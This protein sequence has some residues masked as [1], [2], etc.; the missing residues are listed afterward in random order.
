MIT[1]PT[2]ALMPLLFLVPAIDPP[3]RPFLETHCVRCHNA[4]ERKGNLDL[5]R[6]LDSARWMRLY[7]RVAAGEMPPTPKKPEPA[8]QSGALKAIADALIAHEKPSFEKNGRRALRRLNRTEYENTLR[9]LL[10]LPG[11][12]VKE[13]LPDDGRSHG[14]DKSADAL[15]LSPLLIAKYA[16]AADHALTQAIAPFAVPPVPH[17]ERIYAHHNYDFGVVIPNGDGVMLKDFK[18]DDSRFPIPSDAYAGGKFKGL[19]ELE[20]SRE[21][22]EPGTSGLFRRLG[23]AFAGRLSQFSPTI[24]GRYRIRLSVWS[25]WWEKGTVKP[26]PRTQAAGLYYGARTLGYFDAP[27]LKPREHMLEVHLEPGEYLK[28]DAASLWEVHPYNHKG[29][30]A[31]F[32]GP[33]IALDWLEVEGPLHDEW[34]PVSHKRVLGDLPLVSLDKVPAEERPRRDLPR[35]TARDARN[36]PGRLVPATVLSNRPAADAERL[37]NAFLPRA[38][39]RPVPP[40]TTARYVAIALARLAEGACF[41]DA[42]KAAYKSALCSP[43]FLFLQEPAGPLDTPAL[44]ARLSYFLWASMPDEALLAADLRDPAVLRKHAERM[45]NDPKSERFHADFLDQWLDLRDFELTT[46][47]RTLYPE[48][49]PYLADALRR[50]PTETFKTLLVGN[51]S[52]AT[53]ARA[54][55]VM[56]N[57]RL[58]E[59]YGLT[60]IEGT[61]FR[62]VAVAASGRGGFLTQAAVLKVT[63]N[64]TTTSP[65]KRG[66]WVTRKILGQTLQAPPPDI[67]AVEPDVRG[68]VT[69]REQLAKHRNVPSC[70]SCHRVMDPPGFALE[71]F[72]VIGGRRDRYRSTQKGDPAALDELFV[73]HRSPEGKFPRNLY[74]VGFRAGLAVDPTGQTAQSKAFKNSDEYKKLLDER[75]LARNFVTQLVLYSTGAPI[76]FSDRAAI[77]AILAK[78]GPG[79]RLRTLLLETVQSPLFTHK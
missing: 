54:D 76:R 53:L 41:E 50:E 59:H 64:G 69:I 9:D 44:A 24:A 74:H 32:V 46:P 78:A 30:A 75:L 12:S 26:S 72:D 56:V 19:G 73:S 33:G 4:D 25:F 37:L 36:T 39:R 47:D 29:K 63:A 52:A 66:A 7:D 6:P 42:M 28:F 58:A 35:Q 27:S 79:H 8:A 51:H 23:E 40:R 13:L 34:P 45:L 38:F 16:E 68:A 2:V 48:W 71:S 60:G 20:R 15:D 67:E 70:A 55:F 62:T 1:P 5:T 31:E 14:Y 49:S 77:D 43:E 17:K 18:Y 21:W 3:V 11:L 10:D 65:V 61:R 22:R 57:Q